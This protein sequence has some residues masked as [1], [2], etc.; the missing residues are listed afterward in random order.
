MSASRRRRSA[1][2]TRVPRRIA[3]ARAHAGARAAVEKPPRMGLRSRDAVARA[4]S[5]TNERNARRGVAA[6]KQSFR[7]RKRAPKTTDAGEEA[8]ERGADARGGPAR[9][10]EASAPRVDAGGTSTS[11]RGE[12][13]RWPDQA[14]GTRAAAKNDESVVDVERGGRATPA[15]ETTIT[16]TPSE[17][18]ESMRGGGAFARLGSVGAG[19]YVSAYDDGDDDSDSSD[20]TSED[21][22]AMREALREL[23]FS[24]DADKSPRCCVI[25]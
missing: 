8:S 20:G 1:R 15:L 12:H 9:V 2:S 17:S 23:E 4:N 11:E 13:V 18:D 21:T 19:A 14:F 5:A 6:L 22:R 25:S 10:A 24:R 16:Y 3:R 7:K